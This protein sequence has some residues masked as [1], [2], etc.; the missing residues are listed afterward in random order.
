MNDDEQK[1]KA[2]ECL[3]RAR[4][5]QFRLNL[6]RKTLEAFY[7][8]VYTY[9]E[10]KAEWMI[11]TFEPPLVYVKSRNDDS[12]GTFE[13]QFMPRFFFNLAKD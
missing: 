6:P 3:A 1:T 11:V 5:A 10:L 8:K 4:A 13:Y 12:T 9:E 7:G 2:T